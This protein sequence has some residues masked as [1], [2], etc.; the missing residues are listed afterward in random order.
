MRQEWVAGGG[1]PR[2]VS[3]KYPLPNRFCVLHEV[4][5]DNHLIKDPRFVF[6]DHLRGGEPHTEAVNSLRIQDPGGRGCGLY[7]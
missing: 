6:Y 4:D 7:A 2:G 5:N 1:P 3:I